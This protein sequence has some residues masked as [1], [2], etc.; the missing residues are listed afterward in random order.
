MYSFIDSSPFFETTFYKIKQIDINGAESYSS[1]V[2]L[3]NL[4]S[5]GVTIYPNPSNG[6]VLLNGLLVNDEVVLF[7]SIGE[8]VLKIKIL[9]TT[10]LIDMTNFPKGVYIIQYSSNSNLTYSK[11]ILE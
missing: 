3:N 11:F 8:L 7:N 2:K 6:L 1:L 9:A 5:Y 10:E 4:N